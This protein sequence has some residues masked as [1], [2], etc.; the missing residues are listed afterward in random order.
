M[1][2][3]AEFHS[4]MMEMI[5]RLAEMVNCDRSDRYGS[6][7]SILK[8]SSGAGMS[9][10]AAAKAA[11]GSDRTMNASILEAARIEM[12]RRS[13]QLGGILATDGYQGLINRARRK[14]ADWLRPSTLVW[15]VFPE[16]V[17]AA[18]LSR[19]PLIRVR[20]AEPGDPIL[21]NWVMSP[22]SAGSGGHTTIFR[23]LNYLQRHGYRNRIYFYDTYGSD[24][25]YY[26]N[27]VREY[28]GFTS[29]IGDMRKGMPD[30]DAVIA[31]AWP[32]AYA[33]YN[34]RSAGKRF[35]F[36]Q[37]YEPYFHPVSSSSVFAENTYRMRFH[38]IAAGRWLAEK[39]SQDFGMEADFF[40]FGCD[41]ARYRRDPSSARSGVAFYARF[42]TPRRAVE[43]GL[44]ALELFAKRHPHV[45]LHLF[46][47]Q[48]GRL[49]FKFINHGSTT[50]DRL[51]EIYNRCF[52]GLSLSLTNVSLVP[53]EMLASGCIPIVN[54]AENNRMVL[55]NPYIQYAQ[56]TPHALVGALEAAMCRPDFETLSIQG[57]GSVSSTSWE[58]A[59]AIVDDVLRRALSSSPEL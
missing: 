54:D 52:A 11:S 49:P 9:D 12:A 50:P 1:K 15:P 13:R 5:L 24:L 41:S 18:D 28:Y 21:V 35:Y 58:T 19:P 33:V 20:R 36:V 7:V 51:N 44:L 46:G 42:G 4:P 14:A 45:E 10:Q 34:A 38:G 23:I 30:A 29:E 27:I 3:P 37:D 43:L 40:P 32:S 47:Q 17:I 57:A 53:Y 55:D 26:E 22:P 31:T 6:I 48:L 56:P 16:D 39:L 8:R 59:G 25:K 2:L